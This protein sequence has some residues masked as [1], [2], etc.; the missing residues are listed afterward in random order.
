MVRLALV[1]TTAFVG[2]L[3]SP[4]SVISSVEA[5]QLVSVCCASQGHAGP[6]YYPKGT[7]KQ[8]GYLRGPSYVPGGPVAPQ[9]VARV[10][11]ASAGIIAVP[12]YQNYG[13]KQGPYGYGAVGVG[14]AQRY[15][16][17]GPGGYGADYYPTNARRAPMPPSYA[18]ADGVPFVGSP[19][20]TG[21]LAFPVANTAYPAYA[22]PVTYR[23]EAADDAAQG[24]R[25]RVRQPSAIYSVSPT[26]DTAAPRVYVVRAPRGY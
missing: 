18:V 23:I 20:V 17:A 9:R 14:H 21:Q 1:V 22:P 7:V 10:P 19:A 12:D 2:S 24:G 11:R 5:G 8:S 26:D 15:Q 13:Y 16:Y 6:A 4:F 25:Y 3:A